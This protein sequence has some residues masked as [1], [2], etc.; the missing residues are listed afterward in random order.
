VLA[1]RV[2]P[3]AVV[4]TQ[5]LDAVLAQVRA[6][7]PGATGTPAAPASRHPRPALGTPFVEPDDEVSRSLAALW[8]ELLGIDAVGLHDDFF[9]LGGHSLLGIQLAARLRTEFALEVPLDS[10]FENLTVAR[11]R[12]LVGAASPV[13]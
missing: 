13:A 3:V 10:L 5:D 11:L 7:V 8:Q 6:E 1:H 12:D 2:S 4:S 9:D